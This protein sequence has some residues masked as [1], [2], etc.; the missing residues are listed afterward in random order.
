LH[1]RLDLVKQS[2]TSRKQ[3]SNMTI[4]NKLLSPAIEAQA[5]KEGALNALEAVYVKAR[6]AR[7]KKVNWGGRIFDGIQFGD[8]S[9][10]AVKP[11]AFNRL[12]LVSVEHESMLG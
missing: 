8:G 10:I 3:V 2:M 11:G 1:L 6:Y 4:A 12:T 5:K 9:L 7:F